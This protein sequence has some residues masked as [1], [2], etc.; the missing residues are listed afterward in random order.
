MGSEDKTYI[1]RKPIFIAENYDDDPDGSII[2]ISNGEKEM[3]MFSKE[4]EALFVEFDVD[5]TRKQIHEILTFL[6]QEAF[7]AGV[8]I[9]D[10][11][12]IYTGKTVDESIKR[13]NKEILELL[14]QRQEGND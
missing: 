14:G 5:A 10:N 9:T 11:K 13:V 8:T 3:H 4:L 7:E 12:R 2:R 1:L 6:C